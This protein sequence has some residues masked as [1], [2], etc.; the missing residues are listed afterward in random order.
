MIRF[1]WMQTELTKNL[2]CF[3]PSLFSTVTANKSAQ[4]CIIE[5]RVAD[6]DWIRIQS[7]LWIRIQEGKNDPQK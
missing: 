4:K 3:V 6:P 7:G 1:G 2:L 5:N